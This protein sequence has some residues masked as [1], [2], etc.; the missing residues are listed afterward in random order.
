MRLRAV[1]GAVLLTAAALVFS[2]SSM[3]RAAD[4]APV[5]VAY[6]YPG[7]TG[8]WKHIFSASD[9]YLVPQAAPASLIIPHHDITVSQQNSMYKAA[10]RCVQPD[11]I[12]L[13]GPDH[14]EQGKACIALPADDVEFTA[15]DGILPLDTALLGR[16]QADERLDGFVSVQR[17]MWKGDHAVYSHTP[18]LKK[19]FPE[20]AFLPI[21]LKPLATD[22]EY[23]AFGTLAQ[24]L[25]EVLPQNSLVIASVDFSHYQIPRVTAFHDHATRD[26]IQNREPP[27][28]IEVDSPDT[29]TLLDTYNRLR[30]AVRP[31]LID[32]TSTYDFIPD[33][34]VESTSHQYWAFYPE[35][36]ARA[37]ALFRDGVAA[38]GQRAEC[39]DYARTRN[40][41]ILVCGSGPLHAGIRT[42]WTWD[43]YRTAADPAEGLLRN[44][45]GKEAR[46]LSGFDALIF[47][48]EPGSTFTRTLHGTT[49]RVDS[50]SC[51]D[52][53]NF[54]PPPKERQ[55]VAVLV[56][57]AESGSSHSIAEYGHFAAC[58]DVIVLRSDD[59]SI[60]AAALIAEQP[61]SPRTT[62]QLGTCY[63]PAGGAVSGAVLAL[64]WYN[65]RFHAE[66]FSYEA[67]DGII[68]AIHQFPE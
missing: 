66:S 17:A 61:G 16:I 9:A 24:L 1:F 43:R 52:A 45:A 51:A 12:V 5:R 42:S 10:A 47:D 48:P 18:F 68:P 28:F 65:G 36:A 34:M 3:R 49:L 58:Y 38:T 4:S 15:P 6:Q 53:E 2:C 35:T 55:T 46:F 57:S 60:P 22:D 54:A 29:L 64:N 19:Y 20:A 62:V 13:V 63:D 30:A 50:V 32:M 59:A 67:A 44:L 26:T 33:D 11:V 21:L 56:L 41:T 7:D 39:A 27:R 14:Y 8:M 23:K 40:Q 37:I 25:A 31:V